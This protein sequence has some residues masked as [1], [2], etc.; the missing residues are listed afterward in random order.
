MK[1]KLRKRQYFEQYN[2]FNRKILSN[3]I[4]II[5]FLDFC[6]YFSRKLIIMDKIITTENNTVNIL[7][8]PFICK[9]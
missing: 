9:C 7:N 8:N 2:V 4:I 3:N 6:K 1:Y 5:Y